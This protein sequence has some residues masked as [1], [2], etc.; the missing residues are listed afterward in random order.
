M[1]LK[2]CQILG[3]KP[4]DALAAAGAVE[5]IHNFSLVHDD[6][7]DNDEVRHG[8]PTTHNK[9]GMPLAILAGVVSTLSD[10]PI[11]RP[12]AAIPLKKAPSTREA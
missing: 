2:S 3:G 4:S 10:I 11:I 5:M 7:M 12:A 1:V 9:F 6:I 8:V